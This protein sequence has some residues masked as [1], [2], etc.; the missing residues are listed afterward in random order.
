MEA[1][2]PQWWLSEDRVTLHPLLAECR[3]RKSAK[4]LEL[5]SYV[6]YVTS[7]AHVEVMRSARPGMKEFQLES[8]FKHFCYTYGGCRLEAYTCVCA[9]GPNGATLHYGHS[10]AAN[11]KMVRDGDIALLDMGC[12]YHCYTSDVT[13][14]FPVNGVFSEDQRIVYGAVLAAQRAVYAA[15][16][17]G[18]SWAELHR[19]ASRTILTKL[20][21]GG[22]LTGEGKTSEV[23]AMMVA[24]LGAV[25]MPHGLG[26]FI[27]IDTHDVGGYLAGQPARRASEGV[28]LDK[29]RTARVV[30]AGMYLTVEP[31]CYFVEATLDNAFANPDQAKF[32]VAN[33]IEAL[34]NFGGVRLE[35]D[36]AITA[37]GFINFTLCP[38]TIEEVES[39]MAGGKWPPGPGEDSA[40]ELK[41]QWK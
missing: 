25:F 39:V 40:P 27:G 9:S 18:A 31:G 8:L 16:R 23:D 15:L 19:L 17:P 37:D 13:C 5:L 41:R 20:S 7:M 10:A 33:R 28:A 4:E 36:V 1:A 24:G 29:L 3:V 32:L 21:E 38:R 6:C 2:A 30:Q 26:H 14:S 12:E 34:R 22:V 35:D 11:D